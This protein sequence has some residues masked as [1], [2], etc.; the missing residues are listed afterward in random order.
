MKRLFILSALVACKG[1]DPADTGVAP[2][3]GPVDFVDVIRQEL[4]TPVDIL[5]VIDSSW[6]DGKTEL[7]DQELMNSTFE[8]LLLADPSW[9][10][11]ILDSAASNLSFGL[12]RDKFETWPYPAGAFDL[13]N[14]SNPPKTRDAIYTAL[15]LRLE[16]P[17]NK[18]FIRSNAH[19]Y[20]LVFTDEDDDASEEITENAFQ[21]WLRD[22]QPSN[23]KRLSVITVS[24]KR[25]YWAE[26]TVGG[27][28]YTVG[29]NFE[30]AIDTMFLDAM[31]QRTTF[32]LSYV[33]VE[34]PA[35]VTVVYREHGT[36]YTIDLDYQYDAEANTIS[37]DKVVPPPGAE[38]RV[39]YQTEDDVVELTPTTTLDEP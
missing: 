7:Q 23:S 20:V 33:P 1:D 2:D 22:F 16:Q 14:S 18:E 3:S 13:P 32:P 29:T 37:F 12:I 8:T 36:D 17:Q 4:I 25:D 26:Q 24:D 27:I 31:G 21:E 28:V 11:G 38:I 39:A 6:A 30:K 34:P 9:R 15:D 19:L 35:V 10:M 5:W